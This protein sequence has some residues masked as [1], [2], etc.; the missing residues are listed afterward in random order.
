MPETEPRTPLNALLIADDRPGH[1]TLSEGILAAIARKRPVEITRLEVKRPFWM[2][3]RALSF[4]VNAGLAPEKILQRVYR[5]DPD[6][7][8]TDLVVSAGGN[9]LAANIAAARLTGAPNIFYGSLRRYRAEDFSLVMTSYPNRARL[10]RHLMTLKPSAMDPDVMSGAQI[11]ANNS[12]QLPPTL[13]LIVGGDSG[14]VSYA[15]EDWEQL[16]SFMEQINRTHGTRFVVS[17]AP[18]TPDSVSDCFAGLVARTEGPVKQFLDFRNTGPGSLPELLEQVNVVLVTADSSTM[19]SESVWAR[20]KTI[21]I[22]PGHFSL[23]DE[24][25]G[26]RAW[27]EENA[28]VSGV[29]ISQLSEYVLEDAI[30]MITS[31]QHNPLN[32]L[33]DQIAERLPQ[34]FET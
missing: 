23:P 17:N 25:L 6:V 20:R 13:G 18:R 10:P 14:T 8:P 21:A 16:F 29:E 7:P 4:A 2:P 34:L 5:V 15:P 12:L 1:Y 9:T 27:L 33:A 19:L 28:W 30:S 22:T 3:A 31:L 32:Q 11:E 24:E 26:Y